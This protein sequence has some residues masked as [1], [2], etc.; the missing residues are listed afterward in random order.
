MPQVRH[1][2]LTG[3][4]VAL[5]ALLGLTA[6]GGTLNAGTLATDEPDDAVATTDD[7]A[8]APE[9]TTEVEPSESPSTSA[10]SSAAPTD[11]T[12]SPLMTAFPPPA[13]A[14]EPTRAGARAFSRFYVELLGI[15]YSYG[16]V[17]GMRAHST[18][19]C[20]LCRDYAEEYATIARNGGWVRGDPTW[21][22]DSTTVE[23]FSP[24]GATVAVALTI[25]EHRYAD[26]AL[27]PEQHA[28]EKAYRF[29]FDLHH[30]AGQWFVVAA[31]AAEA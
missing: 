14:R 9:A 25:G 19:A 10:P 6:C 23:R 3:P 17:S 29:S 28:P 2:K 16:D 12:R 13:A 18:D 7:T 30:D 26:S 21:R 22:V 20:G 4:V 15:G 5:L 1:R 8:P 11:G 24:D 31:S 27:E